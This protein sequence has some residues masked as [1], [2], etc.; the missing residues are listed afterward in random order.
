MTKK[1]IAR[2][3]ADENISVYCTVRE[4]GGGIPCRNL[5]KSQNTRTTFVLC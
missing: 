2:F 1:D 4:Y 3:F 5:Q